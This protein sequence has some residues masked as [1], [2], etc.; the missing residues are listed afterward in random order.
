MQLKTH[1]A[2]GIAVALYFLPHVVNPGIFVIVVIFSSLLPDIDSGFSFIGKRPIFK[3]IQATT[4]HRGIF[5]T[6][7]MAA[8]IAIILTF[9]I[10]QISAAFFLGYTSHLF[11]DMFTIRGIKPFWPYKKVSSGIVRTGGP[12]DKSIFISFAFL[13]ILLIIVT[14]ARIVA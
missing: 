5:H 12:I 3:P 7:T 13:D 9:T 6:Y 1:F 10:P 14:L 8:S 2:I 4:K 11:A